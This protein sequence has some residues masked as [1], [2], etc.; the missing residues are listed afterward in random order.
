ML[1]PIV[2]FF[3]LA[4]TRNN[5]YITFCH[6]VKTS[7][8]C[9]YLHICQKILSH[10]VHTHFLVTTASIKLPEILNSDN[11]AMRDQ[12]AASGLVECHLVSA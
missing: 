9:H 10:T 4:D 2:L 5:I 3:S 11:K 1:G 7:C 12:H 8:V 6:P